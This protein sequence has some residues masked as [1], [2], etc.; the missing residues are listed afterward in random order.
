MFI[1]SLIDQIDS[2]AAQ[3]FSLYIDINHAK[4]LRLDY[5]TR[6]RLADENFY[7]FEADE[8]FTSDIL[9]FESVLDDYPE[10][11]QIKNHPLKN[12]PVTLL[13]VI[14][15]RIELLWYEPELRKIKSSISGLIIHLKEEQK[16]WKIQLLHMAEEY[17]KQ[18]NQ[19]L[20][21]NN[22]HDPWQTY[23][24][25]QA[26]SFYSQSLALNYDSKSEKRYQV[27][28]EKLNN[29]RHFQTHFQE[30]KQHANSHCYNQA[31]QEFE[32]AQSLFDTAD[33]K[34]EI[35]LCHEQLAKEHEYN[36]AYNHAK[37]LT[38]KGD[39]QSAIAHLEAAY[40]KFP[41]EDGKQLLDKLQVVI[42]G[43]NAYQK[44]LMAEQQ[45]KW[46]YAKTYYFQARRNSPQF[47]EYC[48]K[49]LVD[50]AIKGE[51]WSL[52]LEELNRLEGEEVHYLRG[53]VYAK[54]GQYKA[55]Y[56]E[57]KAVSHPEIEGEIN[58]LKT[59]V[60]REKLTLMQ[61]IETAV[62]QENLE[63]AKTLSKQFFEQYNSNSVVEHNFDQHIEPRIATLDWKTLSWKELAQ[64]TEASFLEKKDITSLHNWAI[65][66]YYQGQVHPEKMEDWITAWCCAIAN[67]SNDPALKDIPWLG[68]ETIDFEQLSQD[69]KNFL[70]S[71]IDEIEKKNLNQYF[72]LRDQYRMD[73]A[74][75]E[76]CLTIN[77]LK[78]TPSCYQRYQK[79]FPNKSLSN[80]W[81]GALYTSFGKSVAAC[82]N[83]DIKRTFAITPTG[84]DE[85]P[86]AKYGQRYV[87]YHQ[88]IYYLQNQ[89]W[90]K[91]TG[92]LISARNLIQENSNWKDEI[93]HICEEL[94]RNIS[95]Q[96]SLD[97]AQFW[98][99]LL[100]SQLASS[101]YVEQKTNEI[102][103][104]LA[105]EKMSLR[106]G[107]AKLNELRSI[108]RNNVT[109]LELSKQITQI[110]EQREISRL[111]ENRN[112]EEA[113]KKA[114]SSQDERI[115]YM[116]AEICVEVLIEGVKKRNLYQ[117]D[118]MQLGRWAYSLCPNEPSLQNL[119]RDLGLP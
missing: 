67:L 51:E 39:F 5:A 3:A 112:L 55:A 19:A 102:R 94:R 44:G 13:L 87:A 50:I 97:F 66:T 105:D 89:R 82:L 71:H 96:E 81:H 52:A 100:G 76:H 53:F 77:G 64:R 22:E 23:C 91:A 48:T 78:I 15:L 31:I 68:S 85:N 109:L 9:F 21:N 98:Y 75:L 45:G 93:D 115:R 58:K 14:G 99:N 37:E 84:S 114:R 92:I 2:L 113:V 69:L 88:G 34:Q 119:Y 43:K 72:K 38:K 118:I 12:I 26:C 61:H 90:R 29:K 57:W 4:R 8:N 40:T 101:Y 116:V 54:Q 10:T 42:T 95:H 11:S 110:K 46:Q 65:A 32:Q 25:E 70:M 104:Q 83:N 16:K 28:Q 80:D 6:L 17:T 27:C 73:I 30:G 106:E 60:H 36:L 117:E 103:N 62:D 74:A 20:E 59:F 79:Y 41:R 18:A 63:Q 108:D 1:E 35:T 107:K 47:V 33:L 86:A 7:F 49:R 24:L 111:L 56:R